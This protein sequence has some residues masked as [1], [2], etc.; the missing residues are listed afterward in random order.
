MKI[1]QTIGTGFI[2]IIMVLIVGQVEDAAADYRRQPEVP[3][4][5]SQQL[6]PTI[7]IGAGGSINIPVEDTNEFLD[8]NASVHGTLLIPLDRS[9]KLEAD[10]GYW[11]LQTADDFDSGSDD[12]SLLTFTGGIRFYLN[13]LV[14]LDA[15]MGLYRFGDW[16]YT[17]NG[18]TYS[19]EDQNEFGF[20]GGI[21]LEQFPFDVALRVHHSNFHTDDF[22]SVGISARFF[23]GSPTPRW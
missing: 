21:G 18:L 19:Y 6:A 23:F 5:L 8:V 14:H 9:I 2:F 20:Y 3:Q 17:L 10:I 13:Q 22:W 16:E 7:Q 1:I 11:F 4:P 15:G 12:P